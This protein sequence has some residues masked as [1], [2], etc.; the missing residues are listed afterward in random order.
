MI[1]QVSSDSFLEGKK[2]YVAGMFDDIAPKYDFLNH[3]LSLGIDKRWRKQLVK[4]FTSSPPQKILDLATGT[5]DLA[6]KIAQSFNKSSVTGIDISEQMLKVGALKVEKNNLSNRID[7]KIGD[8]ENIEFSDESFVAVIV[9]FGVRNYENLNRG[10][11]EMLRVLKT[12][13]KLAILE[14]SMPANKK[15]LILYKFYFQIILP[16]IGRLI[17]KNFYAYTYLPDS[18]NNFPDPTSFMEVLQQIGYKDVK[19]KKLTFGIC[20]LFTGIK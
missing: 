20:S 16:F 14:F 3:L 10:L 19:C 7:L 17:S 6:I 1:S 4:S 18:V 2:A 8:A 11:S 13:G 15:I 5:A 9:A 12:G